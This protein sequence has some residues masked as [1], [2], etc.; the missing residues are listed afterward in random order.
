MF[1]L[2]FCLDYL[3]ISL[4]GVLKSMSIIV[5]LSI[6]PLR[7]NIFLMY[8][9]AC[10]GC[11]YIY[12]CYI[13]FLDWSLDHYVGP[14][15]YLI[16]VFILK[17]VLTDMSTSFTFQVQV[18]QSD[19]DAGS[20]QFQIGDMSHPSPRS[21]P[22]RFLGV[23]WG[24]TVPGGPCISDLVG[25]RDTPS[26]YEHCRVSGRSDLWVAAGSHLELDAVSRA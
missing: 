21:K 8:W 3:S 15:L 2:T 14:S 22:L 25:G 24:G 10:V 23:P 18:T 20:T 6:F 17:F 5:L 4:S 19:R 13:F 12:N 9:G 16:T 1:W 26:R 11:I 7:V